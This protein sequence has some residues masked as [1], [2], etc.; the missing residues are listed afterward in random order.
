L[1][2]EVQVPQYN[3]LNHARLL[4]CAN[5]RCIQEIQTVTKKQQKKNITENDKVQLESNDEC[6]LLEWLKQRQTDAKAA[7]ALFVNIMNRFWRSLWWVVGIVLK[8]SP[9]ETV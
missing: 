2:P 9:S 8:K 3:I 5:L 7:S 1:F 4:H 6:E